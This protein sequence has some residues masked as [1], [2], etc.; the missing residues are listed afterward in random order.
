MSRQQLQVKRV[1]EEPDVSD[2]TRVL[3]DR[4]WPRGLARSKANI[5]QWCKEV[6]PTTGLRR[7]YGHD[8]D[9]FEEFRRR[10]LCELAE[11]DHEEAVARLRSMAAGS[12]LTL[13]TA[14][15]EVDISA[16]AVLAEHL[17]RR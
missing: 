9:R 14:T 6:A 2:G 13:V 5:D 3:V 7:W 17:Q 15:R 12:P 11:R 8:P 1:Y 4:L 16:A 10:Y